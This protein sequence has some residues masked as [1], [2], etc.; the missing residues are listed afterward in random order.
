MT[1]SPK[2]PGVSGA[3][4]SPVI[5]NT[6]GGSVAASD[7]NQP[8]FG[9]QETTFDLWFSYTRKIGRHIDWKAQLNIR[10]VGIGNEL[11]P[12][13]AN[14]DGQVQV[15]RIRDPQRITLTNTFSF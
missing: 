3:P 12:V 1:S 9:K 11:L 4:S 15:W 7:V 14:P 5:R 8:I 13:Q 6:K 10:N 2:A